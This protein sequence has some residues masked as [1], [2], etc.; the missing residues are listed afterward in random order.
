ML[1]VTMVA[2]HRR[3][4]QPDWFV[5]SENLISISLL[6]SAKNK[7]WDGVLLHDSPASCSCYSGQG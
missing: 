7:A 6:L 5:E 2:G 3:Q 4:R 1:A